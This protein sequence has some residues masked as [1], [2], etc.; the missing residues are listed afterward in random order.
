MT[1]VELR[2]ADGMLHFTGY[3]SVTSKWYSMGGYE[4]LV[5]PQAF[6]RTLAND[7]DVILN[8]EHK[9]LALASTRSQGGVPTLKLAED[10]RGLRA[11][12]E[13]SLDDPDVQYVQR[14]AQ[15]AP[16]EL[17][18]A[19]RV[20]DQ[21]WDAAYEKR[22]IKSVELNR[23]DISIVGRA[24]SPHTVGTVDLRGGMDLERRK[25]QAEAIGTLWRGT[26]RAMVGEIECARCGGTGEITLNCPNCSSGEAE[27]F[28]DGRSRSSLLTLPDLTTH[29]KQE[30]DL[31]KARAR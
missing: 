14:K 9:G 28:D 24:A 2:A 23:G 25:R 10:G 6:R 20:T 16:L 29:A 3:P 12:A 4:E 1:G 8:V 17:S 7:P 27:D 22:E 15:T 26:G 18:F 30:L 21:A 5:K 11:E 31:L 13:L 19:F